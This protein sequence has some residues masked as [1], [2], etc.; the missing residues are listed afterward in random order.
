LQT[1]RLEHSSEHSSEAARGQG[2]GA[3]WRAVEA[4]FGPYGF[5]LGPLPPAELPP[6]AQNVDELQQ[7]AGWQP[8]SYSLTRG[9]A[10]DPIHRP[11]LGPKGH[12]PYEFLAFG[13]LRAGE[14]V[15]FRTG[16]RLSEAQDLHL[17]LAAGA[18]KRAWLNGAALGEAP[19]GNQWLQPVHLEA[20]LNL[21][22]FELTAEE[23]VYLRAAWA[24]VRDPQRFRRPEWLTTPDT[25]AADTLV[26]FSGEFVIPFEPAEGTLHTGTAFSCR[27]LVNGVEA[28]RQGG[29]DPYGLHMR[30]YRHMSTAFRQGRNTVTLEVHDPG[31]IIEAMADVV[32]RGAGGEEATLTS[33]PEWQVQRG[34]GPLGPAAL[35]RFQ[36]RSF[37]PDGTAVT[38]DQPAGD[39][40]RRPHPLA[41]ADWLEDA[42]GD[43]TVLPLVPDAFGGRPRVEWLRWT[44]PPGA[45][46]VRV[47]VSGSARLWVDDVELPLED[48]QAHIPASPALRRK[49]QLRVEPAGGH[50]EGGLLAGPITYSVDRGPI[51]LGA[52]ADYGLASYSGG[53]RYYATFQHDGSD[54]AAL[55]LDLGRVRGT[56]E[57]WVNGRPVGA[58]IWSPYRFAIGDAV[59]AGENAVEVLVCNTLAP[60]LSS[61]SPTHYVFEGQELS[62]LMGPVRVLR[63]R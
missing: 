51:D 38:L 45:T 12:V 11:T 62:G 8:A 57:V 39:L 52:W 42:P 7:S 32:V 24:L 1:W 33:G 63:M 48:G 13:P 10:H 23:A 40:W 61:T 36:A 5:W 25:P 27:V 49:A 37:T 44:L 20:G 41:G 3:D 16:V 22:E 17:A 26:R 56:A 55:V 46:S 60:Y 53:L 28:G 43:D 50:S 9:I 18:A 30:V 6:P 59:Q 54:A 35:R 29:F 19:A 15:R 58:R 47:P 21:L 4:T 2:D 14:A 34:D 31:Q